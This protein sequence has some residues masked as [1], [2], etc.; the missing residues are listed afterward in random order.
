M[1]RPADDLLAKLFGSCNRYAAGE[2]PSRL[3]TT[4]D[5]WW[6]PCVEVDPMLIV[7]CLF[8]LIVPAA[9]VAVLGSR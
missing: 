6:Q 3:S 1:I 5:A 9:A 7:L 4:S 2:L 8:L